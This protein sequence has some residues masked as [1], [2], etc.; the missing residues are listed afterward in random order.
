MFITIHPPSIAFNV[1]ENYL[2]LA[3]RY[4]KK[5]PINILKKLT[6]NCLKSL[7]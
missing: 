7:I 4:S 1:I 3:A 6:S 5:H 2:R